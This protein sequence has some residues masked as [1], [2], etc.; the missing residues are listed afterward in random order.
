MVV[1]NK[2]Y[3]VHNQKNMETTEKTGGEGAG[4][5]KRIVAWTVVV[6]LLVTILIFG[7]LKL[8]LDWLGG[9]VDDRDASLASL[10]SAPVLDCNVYGINIHGSIVTYKTPEDGN[11]YTPSDVT[12][13]ESVVGLVS[14]AKNDPKIKAVFLEIDSAG[15][16]PV[17]GE[18]IFTALKNLGKPSV[19]MIRDVGASAAYMAAI[20]TDIIIASKFSDVGSIGIT[21]SY[22]DNA[23][24]NIKEGR[25]YNSLSTGKYKDMG[26]PDKPLTAEEKALIMRDLQIG[27]NNF[28]K[29]VAENRN[30]ELSKVEKLADGSSMPGEM[31]LQNGL[32][33]EIGSY[34]EVSEYLKSQIG[35]VPVYCW[36]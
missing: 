2:K 32:I 28:V 8:L 7:G 15:G 19:A 29:M 20:G 17:A 3:I 9:P 18:E 36:E 26:D 6:Y 14:D 23:Q 33:D 35:A 34:K 31:A 12:A 13:S 1:S 27:H 4:R 30:L 16:S 25:T 5:M 24:K 22:L 21:M 11:E 10:N